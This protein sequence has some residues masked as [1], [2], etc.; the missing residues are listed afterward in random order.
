MTEAVLGQLRKQWEPAALAL[1]AKGDWKYD[2]GFPMKKINAERRPIARNPTIVAGKEAALNIGAPIPPVIL[3]HTKVI[4][5]PGYEPID[6]WHGAKAAENAG[7]KK[8]PA[9]IGEGDAE[10]TT[11]IVKIDDTIPTPPTGPGQ[12]AATLPYQASVQSLKENVT[13]RHVPQLQNAVSRV[14]EAQKREVV[15]RVIAHY[16][17]IARKPKDS[18]IWWPNPAE[19]DTALRAAIAPTTGAIAS[20]VNGYVND[21]LKKPEGA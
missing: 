6:G 1:V 3:V 21:L 7:L 5:K 13:A 2:A 9:Y 15:G 20:T 8:I 18:T 14:L 17:Q 11:A 16:D 10:W 19:K 4:G 12:K